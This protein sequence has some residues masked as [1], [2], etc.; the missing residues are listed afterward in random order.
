MLNTT[1]HK[2]EILNF[3]FKFDLIKIFLN[4]VN[5]T[6]GSCI[7]LFQSNWIPP[8]NNVSI[9]I[10]LS[11]HIVKALKR[12]SQFVLLFNEQVDQRP[13]REKY[14]GINDND[15]EMNDDLFQIRM[16]CLFVQSLSNLLYAY[17][18]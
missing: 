13:L 6:F 5:K 2:K 3:S 16:R 15:D 8:V 4:L 17:R 1:K 10:S 11:T 12:E 18:A 9:C 7:K 14:L